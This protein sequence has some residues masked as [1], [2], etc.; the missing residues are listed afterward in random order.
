MKPVVWGPSF[1]EGAEGKRKRNERVID[2]I[3][4]IGS[5]VNKR[6]TVK[7]EDD[8]WGLESTADKTSQISPRI[9][10]TNQ[11]PSPHYDL[12]DV[13]LYEDVQRRELPE[14]KIVPR[15]KKSQPIKARTT[16]EVL[17][18]PYNLPEIECLKESK[19]EL[20]QNTSSSMTTK[21]KNLTSPENRDLDLADNSKEAELKDTSSSMTTQPKNLTSPKNKKLDLVDNN[22]DVEF[23]DSTSDKINHLA[24]SLTALAIKARMHPKDLIDCEPAA[25]MMRLGKAYSTSKCVESGE[26]LLKETETLKIKIKKVVKDFNDL[27]EEIKKVKDL[28]SKVYNLTERQKVLLLR[29]KRG[30][31]G[32]HFSDEER[33]FFIEWID[34]QGKTPYS[35]EDKAFLMEWMKPYET[36]LNEDNQ[37]ISDQWES[38][39]A[40]YELMQR[41]S[42]LDEDNLSEKERTL[43]LQIKSMMEKVP[44]PLLLCED[45]ILFI[46]IAVPFEKKVAANDQ[47]EKQKN[48]KD[49]DTRISELLGENKTL[50]NQW[51]EDKS[52]LTKKAPSMIEWMNNQGYTF[53]DKVLIMAW[54]K[55]R[56][57]PP[58][59]KRDDA[60]IDSICQMRS[61]HKSS[62]GDFKTDLISLHKAFKDCSKNASEVRKEF[63]W[64][65]PKVSKRINKDKSVIY[66]QGY[67]IETLNTFAAYNN[68]EI[69]KDQN[70]YDSAVLKAQKELH[71]VTSKFSK[72]LMK[73]EKTLSTMEKETQW[74]TKYY[75]SF[76][77]HCSA[78]SYDPNGYL[79]ENPFWLSYGIGNHKYAEEPELQ[80][81]LKDLVIPIGQKNPVDQH[82]AYE[83]SE[84]ES[85]VEYQIME[86]ASSE[87]NV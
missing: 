15:T 4:T 48:I 70:S 77:A 21:P 64:F 63:G 56:T 78:N 2:D 81:N 28:M 35:V 76:C 41:F 1:Q 16:E 69:K 34:I 31:I 59:T 54:M 26:M 7:E 86:N 51:R 85:G 47:L 19:K 43:A 22:K 18:D 79:V 25:L 5:P 44:E 3:P 32:E 80:F 65:Q 58:Y 57:L 10:N 84:V 27:L 14:I 68:V 73:M 29:W 71:D 50:W 23:Q 11:E 8:P 62:Y 74:W 13:E 33:G 49:F 61:F 55:K 20:S 36:K 42:R 52:L 60:L 24:T 39:N 46:S 37:N 17:L 53:E 9:T 6:Y 12:S 38:V 83:Y 72:F 66:P 87:E 67:Q 40:I 45:Q 75:L 82:S 30:G